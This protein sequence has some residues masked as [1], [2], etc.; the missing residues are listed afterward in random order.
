MRWTPF[1]LEI[2]LWAAPWIGTGALLAVLTGIPQR[3]GFSNGRPPGLVAPL[4]VFTG[5]AWILRTW[6]RYYGAARP[7]KIRELM[8]DVTVSQMRPRAVRLEGTIMGFGVPG[9]FWCPDL[10]LRDST[11]LLYVLYRQSIP[12]ARLFFAVSTADRYI[13]QKVVIE[14]WFRRGLRPYIE[15]SCLTGEDG[16][17]RRAYSRWVQYAAAALVAL[18]GLV[19]AVMNR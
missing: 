13:G 4:L 14:G 5:I 9:A 12:F 1:P 6:F 16:Q 11:G 7:A 8:E 17:P 2:L 19:L 10:V 18:G 3:F 15:M